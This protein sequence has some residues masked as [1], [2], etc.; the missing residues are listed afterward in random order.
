MTRWIIACLLI[1]PA[2][3]A[4]VVAVT[5]HGVAVATA[6]S[7]QLFDRSG[8]EVLWSGEGVE[9]PTAVIGSSDR[10]AAIDSINNEVRVAD[11][12]TGRGRTVRTGETPIDGVF[13]GAEFFLLARDARL[14]ERIGSDGVRVSVTVAADPAFIRQAGNR[15]YVYSRVAGVLQEITISPFAVNRS[16]QAAPFASDLELDSRNAYLVYPRAAKI[17]VVSLASMTSAGN[18]DVGAVPVDVAF[19]SRST[20]LS[21]R[22]LA[23]ADPSAK[24]VWMIEGVQSFTQAVTRGFLR[25]LLGL[26]LF[27]GGAS[28]FPTGVDRVIVRGSAWFAFDTSSG[29]LYRFTK[30]RSVVLAK[31]IAPSAFSVGPDGVFIWN[32]A[33]RRL[34]RLE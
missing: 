15:I 2:A 21:A 31:G 25:G 32:D 30:S 7:L 24:R 16:A 28:Q 22:T 12:S 8:R 11:L 13:V 18:I 26:G 1:A 9:S 6:G 10:I 5:P 27:G 19:A 4:Q 20:A 34:Q 3:F 33:V 29:T 17:G 14:V 23:V